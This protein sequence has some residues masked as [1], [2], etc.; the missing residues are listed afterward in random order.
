M[1]PSDV[2]S[3]SVPPSV[4]VCGVTVAAWVSDRSTSLKLITPLSLRT[5]V[6]FSIAAPAKSEPED[7]TLT[8]SLVPLTV[9]VTV[10]VMVE[11]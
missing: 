10:W 11:P 5:T 3:S 9:T 1:T 8:P 4:P 6:A 2:L 7:S